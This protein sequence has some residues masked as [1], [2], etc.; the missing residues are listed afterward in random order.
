M[1]DTDGGSD[2]GGGSRSPGGSPLGSPGA[3]LAR[4]IPELLGR[5][6]GGSVGNVGSGR[7]LG[8]LEEEDLN[9][10]GASTP[11]AAAAAALMNGGG[12]GKEGM[13]GDRLGSTS[14][15]GSKRSNG[16]NNSSSAIG[17]HMR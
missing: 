15:M 6:R 10:V 8:G 7:V 9:I 13:A 14:S 2:T 17:S 11:V 3:R 1:S 4:M 16:S 5:G 12:G